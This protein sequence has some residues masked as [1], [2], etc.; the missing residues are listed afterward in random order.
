MKPP[1]SIVYT[2]FS[3]NIKCHY[4]KYRNYEVLFQS[5]KPIF[6]ADKL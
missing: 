3:Y 5:I 6:S 1:N 2:T 4:S